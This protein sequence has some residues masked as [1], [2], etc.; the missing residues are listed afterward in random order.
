MRLLLV[1]ALSDRPASP[2]LRTDEYGALAPVP[3]DDEFLAAACRSI[4]HVR[5]AL[6][7][8]FDC[9]S[10]AQLLLQVTEPRFADISA[11]LTGLYHC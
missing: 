7:Q 10:N 5:Q 9:N 2:G 8:F 11:H 3:F 6:L 1:Q 4:N